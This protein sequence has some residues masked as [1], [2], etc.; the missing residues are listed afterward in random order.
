[1]Q[2]LN[3]PGSRLS[4]LFAKQ[5]NSPKSNNLESSLPG[6]RITLSLLT[7]LLVCGVSLSGTAAAEHG[8][9]NSLSSADST[10]TNS[11]TNDDSGSSTATTEQ[12]TEVENH[13]H[14]LME[15]FKQKGREQLQAKEHANTRSLAVRQKSCEARKAGLIRRMSNAVA[16]AQ[17]H[18]DVFDKIYTKVKDFHDTKNLNVS[19]YDSLVA[20]VHAAQ[21]DAAAKVAALK[22]LEVTVDCTQVDSLAN[23]VSAFKQAVGASRDSLKDYRKA[24]V[25]LVSAL[26]GAS[27][28]QSSTD[29]N[30][31]TNNTT[32]TQ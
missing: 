20:S 5:I 2:Q 23:S 16:A 7:L 15:Q 26:H 9:D 18:K 11:D 12:E 6:K 32:T 10:T 31:T 22:G 28:A 14:D 19:N 21:N 30:S 24:L 1:M 29:D 17:R 8:P 13:S 25:A 27:T 3:K 4:S